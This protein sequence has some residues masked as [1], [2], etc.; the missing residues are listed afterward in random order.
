MSF[1]LAVMLRES[2]LATPDTAC[3]IHQGRPITYRELDDLSSR[4]ARGLRANGL[5]R[6]D[7][8]AICLPNVPEFVVAYFGALKAGVT[9]MPLSPLL[10]A[11]EIAYHLTDS[12]ARTL[13]AFDVFATEALGAA[14]AVPGTAV[15]IVTL[16]EDGP[17]PQG[18]LAFGLLLP[19]GP[20]DRT[21][22]IR[23]DIEPTSSDDTAVLLYTSGTTGRP[24]GAELTHFQLY[25]NC[26]TSGDLFDV[27]PGDVSLGALPLFHVY[28][29]SSVLNVCVRYGGTVSLVLRFEAQS[30]LDQMV[31]DRVSVVVGVPT[32]YVALLAADRTGR[33]LSRL[34][35]GSSGGASMPGEV[36][37]EFEEAFGIVILEGYG[38]SE[39]AST[40]TFNRSADDRRVLSVGKPI[41]GVELRVADP[42]DVPLPPGAEHV[43][44]ILLRG[45]NII[46]RYRR[47]ADATA[48]A[49]R[50]GWFH[51]GDLGYLD[52]DGFLFVV[53]RKKDLVIRGGYNVYP[54]EVE[55]VLYTHPAIA[56]AAVVGRPDDRL[57]EEVVAVVA[58]RSG[59]AADPDEII[60]YCRERMAA[61]KY[62]RVVRIMDELPKGASGKIMKKELRSV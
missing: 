41:W 43:G 22:L 47:D 35:V 24:K 38:L 9:L 50:N 56:E 51:T 19:D 20:P 45:H 31:R 62:P 33:D 60:A 14:A 28:G 30:V 3:L 18:T 37:R 49:F 13:L 54:R 57:G 6:D 58:L 44:E 52:D 4:F 39:S 2:R 7:V 23:G 36:I 59:E 32:M 26:T 48:E 42:D 10:K 11:T 8:L 12:G 21:E 16:A 53:D 46:T 29:L 55:E 5:G 25:L 40:A 1:N 61:Y 15:Y 34:R 27:L 17:V